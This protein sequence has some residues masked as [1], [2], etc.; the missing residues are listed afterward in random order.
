MKKSL[1]LT[2]ASLVMMSLASCAHTAQASAPTLAKSASYYRAWQGFK[3]SGLSNA[4]FN[5]DFPAF[6]Q[7][8]VDIYPHALNN[9]IVV[10]PPANKPSYIPDEF[11]LVALTNEAVYQAVRAT[12][13]GK[14]YGEA[15]WGFFDKSVSKSAPMSAGLPTELVAGQSYDMSGG[16]V[17]WSRGYNLFFLGTRKNGQSV[18]EYLTHLRSHVALAKKNLAPIGMRGYVVVVGEN[19]EAAFINWESKEA[20]DR[21]FAGEG[22][23]AI[24]NDAGTFMDIMMWQPVGALK[25]GEL[26]PGSVYSADQG[27][28]K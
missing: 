5:R 17:D 4:D 14:A 26:T 10:I 2:L 13:E 3:R 16:A 20:M 7:K 22:G 11:A 12:D 21:A 27:F 15:H 19:Y 8:T 6:M 24:G 1:V 23:K 28:A 9:Y 18:S 25:G